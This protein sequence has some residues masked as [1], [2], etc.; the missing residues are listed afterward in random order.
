MD[1]FIDVEKAAVE[2]DIK[3][4]ARREAA[5]GQD[6]VGDGSL[7]CLVAEN[8]VRQAERAGELR[9]RAGRIHAGRKILHV[10]TTQGLVPCAKR[11]TLGG[12]SPSERLGKPGNHH[13]LPPRKSLS[14]Y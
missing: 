10:E 14:W 6:A 8:R 1:L 2:P 9:V 4:P 12:T 13:R 7:L 5:C 3:R 11:A